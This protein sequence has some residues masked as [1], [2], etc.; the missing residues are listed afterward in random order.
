MTLAHVHT[1]Q[2]LTT[3]AA[4]VCNKDFAKRC[5]TEQAKIDELKEHSQEL[6]GENKNLKEDVKL[7]EAE[8][9]MLSRKTQMLSEQQGQLITEK[10]DLVK[11]VRTLCERSCQC[12]LLPMQHGAS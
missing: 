6:K 11:Q 9:A 1:G 3:R 12:L 7:L 10:E 8:R 2:S 5:C 4:F